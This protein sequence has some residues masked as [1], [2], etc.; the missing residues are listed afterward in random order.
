MTC[1]PCTYRSFTASFA[2]LLALLSL[3]FS[4]GRSRRGI[5]RN[6][7]FDAS[8]RSLA[9]ERTHLVVRM[10]IRGFGDRDKVGIDLNT[11]RRQGFLIAAAAVGMSQ[12]SNHDKDGQ[13]VGKCHNSRASSHHRFFVL[14]CFYMQGKSN[15]MRAR[16]IFPRE[17]KIMTWRVSRQNLF[18]VCL[19]FVAKPNAK[20]LLLVVRSKVIDKIIP[21]YLD[22][23]EETRRYANKTSAR[24]SRDTPTNHQIVMVLLPSQI[25]RH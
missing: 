16:E 14:V 19:D 6:A 12:E 15:E 5:Q 9:F 4:F 17:R 3:A 22:I 7:S 1:L 2:S 23:L 20:S 24:T 11:F 8:F 18:G 13:Q 25:R 21:V 10:T